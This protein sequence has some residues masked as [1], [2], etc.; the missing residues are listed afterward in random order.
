[1]SHFMPV[2]CF[3]IH[4]SW[5]PVAKMKLHN[6]RSFFFDARI[7]HEHPLLPS[8]VLQAVENIHTR[9]WLVPQRATSPFISHLGH[10]FIH[11]HTFG[12]FR[13]H[14]LNS[15]VPIASCWILRWQ[16]VKKTFPCMSL[17]FLPSWTLNNN[18]LL[19]LSGF[20][21]MSFVCVEPCQE[22]YPLETLGPTMS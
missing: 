18:G 1:M 10:G 20:L 21:T 12:C 7:N 2:F 8:K 5:K 17:H 11:V 14:R 19:V 22:K 16:D 6:P 15:S 13:L 3:C 4:R 9:V